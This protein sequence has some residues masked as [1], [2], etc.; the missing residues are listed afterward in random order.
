[1]ACARSLAYFDLLRLP[2]AIVNKI[3]QLSGLFA[4]CIFLKFASA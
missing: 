1:M 3:D 2:H 4:V